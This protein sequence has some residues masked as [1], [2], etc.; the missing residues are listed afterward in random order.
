MYLEA[1]KGVAATDLIADVPMASGNER[2][3]YA[4]QKPSCALGAHH[5]VL[6]VILAT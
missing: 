5:K 3:G 4:T 2:M 1:T 6:L